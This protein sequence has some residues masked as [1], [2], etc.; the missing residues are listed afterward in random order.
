[1]SSAYQFNIHFQEFMD[2]YRWPIVIFIFIML[3][4]KKLNRKTI[5]KNKDLNEK[6]RL[7][8]NDLIH[9]VLTDNVE[10]VKKQLERRGYGGNFKASTGETALELAILNN[11]KYMIA[12]LIKYG[13]IPQPRDL[14]AAL[15]SKNPDIIQMIKTGKHL[16]MIKEYEL[17][18]KKQYD[19]I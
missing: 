2:E 3:A 6:E 7:L 14:K 1:M 15:T 17:L 4:L 12:Y 9:Y 18:R 16:S 11:S 8:T 19:L 10:A 5:Q 13:A